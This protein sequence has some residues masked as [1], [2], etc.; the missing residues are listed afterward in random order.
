MVERIEL[1]EG[2]IA[3]VQVADFADV[4]DIEV[5]AECRRQ[6]YGRS[7]MQLF[8]DEMKSRGVVD[9]T[10]EVRVDN[11]AAIALYEKF[12][13]ERLSIRKKYYNDGCDGQLMRLKVKK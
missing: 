13:F 8:L 7:L 12:G 2:F 6:G 11:V 9:V 4:Y 5:R 3:F 1:A 10:L